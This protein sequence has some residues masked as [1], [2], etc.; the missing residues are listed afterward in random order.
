MDIEL[1]QV[2]HTGLIGIFNS[3]NNFTGNI[4]SSNETI[5]I[6]KELLKDCSH[7]HKKNVEYLKSK[8]KRVEK[9]YTDSDIYDC[10]EHMKP[11]EVGKKIK[12]D[13]NLTIELNWNSH[14]LGSC[15][16]TIYI[17]KPNSNKV[18]S[19]VYSSDMGSK[20]NKK[21]SDYLQ[22]QKIP[23]SCTAF[24]S[25]ATYSDKNRSMDEM[26]IKSERKE[27][28][29][30]IKQGLLNGNQILLPVFAFSRS[31]QIVTNLWKELSKEQWFIE[32]EYKVVMDG[33]LMNNINKAY[34]RVLQGE[35]KELFDDVMNW[36]QLVKIDSF[37]GTMALLSKKEPRIILASS[38]FLENGKICTYLPQ[39]LGNRNDIVILTG[40]CSQNNIGSMGWKLTNSSQKTI[41]FSDKQ[42]ILKRAKVYQQKS[43]SSH[44]TN[45][46]LKEL[47]AS[48]NTDK[49]IIHHCDE[50]NKEEFLK[51]CKEY[52]R[53]NNKTT[54]IV[55]TGKGCN[56]FVF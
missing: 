53:K 38:G 34:S 12:I 55:A 26:T 10:F 46:E 16:A 29:E 52:M 28:I 40:Y 36:K 27:F 25:E 48:L 50:D 4:I 23:K 54:K 33:T 13:D 14:V 5:E 18:L 1:S 7:I 22:E 15:N 45:A 42:T 9:I 8:G 39:I 21:Y 47:F 32:G 24:I 30:I 56:Q 35:D 20:I 3:S 17:K 6:T 19:F 11:I 2:D 51:D 41:T 44:I 43:W 37:D 49:I 31:Q